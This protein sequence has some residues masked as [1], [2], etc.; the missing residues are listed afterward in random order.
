[1]NLNPII[2]K[3]DSVAARYNKQDGIRSH[4]LSEKTALFEKMEILNEFLDSKDEVQ[5]VLHELQERTQSKT[6]GIYEELLT[7]LVKDIMPDNDESDRVILNTGV[8]NNR[9]TLS[10][11]VANKK[12]HPRD[13]YKDKGGSIENIIAMG[14]RF[15]SLS[16]ASNRRFLILDEADAWLK[17][18]YIPAFAEV[19]CQLSRRV[20]IQ[21]V[22]ISHHGVENF[23]GKAKIIDLSRESGKI[24]AE[25][26]TH[27]HTPI[28]EGVDDENL[29][30][31]MEGV[32][33]R[34]LRLVNFKQH[35]NTLLELSPN[36]TIITG[37]NDIGKT[38]ILQAIEAVNHNLGR[39]GLIRDEQPSCRVEM[40]LEDD[41]SLVWSY[42]RKGQKKTHY[43][44]VDEDGS[45]IKHS[46]S[47][48]DVPEWL[49]DYLAMGL[50]KDF[51]LHIG[52]QHNASFILDTKIS[53]HKRAEILSLGKEAS[54]V[55]KMITLHGEKVTSAKRELKR[56]DK[57]MNNIKNKLAVMRIL[58]EKEN[59]LRTVYEDLSSIKKINDELEHIQSSAVLI[60]YLDDKRLALEP[61]SN[62][63]ALGRVEVDGEVDGMAIEINKLQSLSD[64]LN[65][66]NKVKELQHVQV[67]SIEDL[68][69]IQSLIDSIA[70]L[71]E[72]S[73][74]LEKV[75]NLDHLNMPEIEMLNEL[76]IK[77]K[78]I[79]TL[80]KKVNSYQ[81]VV[82]L[83]PI[84]SDDNAIDVDPKE[85]A[86]TGSK[87]G[88]L[89]KRKAELEKQVKT[90]ET[91]KQ[92]L[93]IE[94]KN[95][96]DSI[97]GI[98]PT[99]HNHIEEHIS[100]AC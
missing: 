34:Y 69:R 77:G 66:L 25:D 29:P 5:E 27:E 72:K 18:I 84:E 10:V 78:Q 65:V 98:C 59:A 9:T 46:D 24:I 35:E 39:D 93:D 45:V 64:L 38:T 75:V 82:N 32:G 40:G 22:Y 4:F 11:E 81:K 3:F 19:L 52:D 30:T 80:E 56:A 13:V 43:N 15:I 20:G 91:E 73:H 7:K 33:I 60:K 87:I 37:D 51:D 63:E 53:A 70:S 94:Y 16:R 26:K 92:N 97:G 41:I 49:H 12:G 83:N 28:F 96:V 47:G 1:M 99:C 61:L 57:E 23:A 58:F 6:R 36:V 71:S 89:L 2:E 50:Y 74:Y 14:L 85:I 44:L 95:F 86:T 90:T 17:D 100:E 55:Q 54:K 67:L 42:S 62:V 21:V 31:L 88:E 8:K 48:K 76:M 68:S 79:A